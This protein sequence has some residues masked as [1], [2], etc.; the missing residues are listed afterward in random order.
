[1]SRSCLFQSKLIRLFSRQLAFLNSIDGDGEALE[2]LDTEIELRNYPKFRQWLE[3]VGLQANTIQ[4]R[5]IR[6]VE[7]GDSGGCGISEMLVRTG[8]GATGS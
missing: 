6:R 4:V 3:V 8:A 1:M 2:A 7:S 5:S